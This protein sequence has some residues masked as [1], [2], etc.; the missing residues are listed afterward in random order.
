MAHHPDALQ[1]L[2]N[3]QGRLELF[4]DGLST[5]SARPRRMGG[6]STTAYRH[7]EIEAGVEP[8]AHESNVGEPPRGLSP[9]LASFFPQAV[10][11]VAG[12]G[13]T[14]RYFGDRVLCFRGFRSRLFK[15]LLLQLLTGNLNLNLDLQVEPKRL[16]EAIETGEERG[17]VDV[18]CTQICQKSDPVIS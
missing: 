11:S 14:N 4:E 2:V 1:F 16:T 10:P 6:T 13:Q 18:H 7:I 8:A 15:H 9:L 12:I 3:Q 17:P 5:K